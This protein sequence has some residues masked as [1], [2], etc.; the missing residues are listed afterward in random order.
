MSPL[1]PPSPGA[2]PFAR[3]MKAWRR[4]RKVLGIISIYALYLT[5]R[6]WVRDHIV[7]SPTPLISSYGLWKLA[8]VAGLDVLDTEQSERRRRPPL[9]RIR[10]VDATWDPDAPA[11]LLNGRCRD[12]SKSHVDDVHQTVFGYC[13]KLD[14]TVFQGRAVM[15]PE[16][17]SQEGGAFVDCPIA[18]AEVRT[19]HIYQKLVDNA[20][21]ANTVKEYRVLVVGNEIVDVIVQ[22]RGA[23]QRLKGRGS[24]GGQ[25]WTAE[26]AHAVFTAD[27]HASILRFCE[28]IGLEFGELDVLPDMVENRIYILDANKTPSFMSQERSFTLE[29]FRQLRRRADAFYRILRQRQS[30]P[31]SAAHQPSAS[32][33]GRGAPAVPARRGQ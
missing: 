30:M 31:D 5:K 7:V 3:L 23:P 8:K 29:R 21:D 1:A 22:F 15:K 28:L 24:G 16:L 11:G 2:S 13:T 6:L 17:N 26:P 19:D 12:I 32:S 14:P 9:A 33:R 4:P 10:H 18:P 25:G 20:V 27:E